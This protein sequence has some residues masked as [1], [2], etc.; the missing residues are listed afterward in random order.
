MSLFAM[1]DD[2]CFRSRDVNATPSVIHRLVRHG[3][4]E[5][6]DLFV[7]ETNALVIPMLCLFGAPL[8]IIFMRPPFPFTYGQ[9]ACTPEYAAPT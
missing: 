5:V 7:Y 6:F 9:F 8:V 1:S 4:L 2:N 3:Y